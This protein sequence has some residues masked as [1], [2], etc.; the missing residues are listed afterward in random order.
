[1][2]LFSPADPTL[3]TGNAHYSGA[4]AADPSGVAESTNGWFSLD[5]PT[6]PTGVP[7]MASPA[8]DPGLDELS[9]SDDTVPAGAPALPGYLLSSPQAGSPAQKTARRTISWPRAALAVAIVLL[10]LIVALCFA[11]TRARLW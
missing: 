8:I 10:L 11:A 6:I 3:V 9:P 2:A 4:G 1:G 5:D 7:I